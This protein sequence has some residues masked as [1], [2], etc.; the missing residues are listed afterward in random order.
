MKKI[1]VFVFVLAT[2]SFAVGMKIAAMDKE[3]KLLPYMNRLLWVKIPI[4]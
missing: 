4:R 2:I 3:H 1:I